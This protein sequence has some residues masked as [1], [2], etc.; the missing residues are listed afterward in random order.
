M[1]RTQLNHGKAQLTVDAVAGRGPVINTVPISHTAST[2]T[3]TG[4]HLISSSVLGTDTSENMHQHV[5]KHL[6][7]L[8]GCST[9]EWQLAGVYPVHKALPITNS[10]FI[11]QAFP[12]VGDFV[13]VAG[14]HMRVP[15]INS[16]MES[17]VT[18]AKAAIADLRAR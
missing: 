5:K 6:E 14:D 13:Y 11:E 15:S 4:E 16:A 18:A 8:Y 3:R 7:L 17:G 12:K 9:A 1:A 10:P 2:Y